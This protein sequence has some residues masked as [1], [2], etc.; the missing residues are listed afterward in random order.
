MTQPVI[1]TSELKKYYSGKTKAL[2]GVD[3][4]VRAKSLSP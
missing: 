4:D 3:L 1:S 2:D